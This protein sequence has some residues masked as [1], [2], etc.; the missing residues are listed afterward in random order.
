VSSDRNDR[1]APG[2]QSVHPGR[3]LQSGQGQRNVYEPEADGA[4]CFT[5]I[6]KVGKVGKIGKVGK[7]GRVGRV[8]KV[9]KVGKEGKEGRLREL[10]VANSLPDFTAI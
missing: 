1:P 10:A 4:R 3:C 9:G 8:G 6:G 5:K 2:G 7:V